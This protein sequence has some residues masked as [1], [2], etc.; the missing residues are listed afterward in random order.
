VLFNDA[1]IPPVRDEIN[2][3]WSN[4]EVHRG[5]S[6]TIFQFSPQIPHVL[7]WEQLSVMRKKI[8]VSGEVLT[9]VSV[10]ITFLSAD[11]TPCGLV[12]TY[13]RFRTTGCLHRH[14][15]EVTKLCLKMVSAGSSETPVHL[16]QGSANVT[17]QKT[18]KLNYCGNCKQRRK[19]ELDNFSVVIT[20]SVSL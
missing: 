5:K 19:E 3:V 8:N 9:A 14:V 17:Y 4:T 1:S 12:E 15:T 16:Y 13:R 6:D 10:N 2:Y 20:V 7:P 11:V 18:E